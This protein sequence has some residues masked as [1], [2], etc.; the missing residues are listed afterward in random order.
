MVAASPKRE[1]YQRLK[2]AMSLTAINSL[3]EG[4]ATGKG[5][6]IPFQ[7]WPPM[8]AVTYRRHH[9]RMDACALAGCKDCNPASSAQKIDRPSCGTMRI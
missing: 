5:H 2:G 4:L 9:A 7:V 8:T 1:R 6:S 3:I